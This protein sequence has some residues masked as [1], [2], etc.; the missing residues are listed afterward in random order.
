MKALVAI[1]ALCLSACASR[2]PN[3]CVPQAIQMTEG[4][5]GKGI[6]AKVL[7]ITAPPMRHAV[8]VYL[9]PAGANRL[10]VW[11]ATWASIRV[12]AY[13]DQPESVA[14]GWLAAIR[15]PP[16]LTSAEYL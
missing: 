11:D 7:L 4:L 14:R 12:R 16:T 8:S 10:W 6:T 9:Y 2:L 1:L 5:K 15:K 13:F 3:D